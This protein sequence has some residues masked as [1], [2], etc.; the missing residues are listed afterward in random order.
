MAGGGAHGLVAQLGDN[1]CACGAEGRRGRHGKLPVGGE[2]HAHG[3]AVDNVVGAVDNLALQVAV[4]R[5][6]DIDFHDLALG[7]RGEHRAAHIA[8]RREA[9]DFTAAHD[10]GGAV[11]GPAHGERQADDDKHVA[12]R[13]G[14][15]HA[16]QGLHRRVRQRALIE[17]VPAGAARQ[18]QLGE[19]ERL[20]AEGFGLFDFFYN[21]LCVVSRVG[22]PYLRG[23]GGDFQETVLHSVTITLFSVIAPSGA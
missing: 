9:E 5:F 8:A 12:V 21:L 20:H 2:L 1:G 18:A 6:V 14:L 16:E 23:R 4:I 13:G 11:Q 3:E 7:Q 17:E 10:G 19:H 22:H 15:R